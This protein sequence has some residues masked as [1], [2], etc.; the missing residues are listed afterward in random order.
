MDE[1]VLVRFSEVFSVEFEAKSSQEKRANCVVLRYKSDS[2]S[3]SSYERLKSTCPLR[4]LFFR[5][6]SLK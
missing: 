6:I 4:G 1:H 5:T 2:Y 3:Q